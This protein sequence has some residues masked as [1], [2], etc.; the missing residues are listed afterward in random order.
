MA[1]LPALLAITVASLVSTFF[2]QANDHYK[3]E[4]DFAYDALAKADYATSLTHLEKAARLAAIQQAPAIDRAEIYDTLA[5]INNVQRRYAVAERYYIKAFE[6]LNSAQ[7]EPEAASLA[8]CELIALYVQQK[9]YRDAEPYCWHGLKAAE[10]SSSIAGAACI[11]SDLAFVQ[12]KQGKHAEALNN[13]NLSIPIMVEAFGSRSFDVAL[14]NSELGDTYLRLGKKAEA[15]KAYE[16]A[17]A[18]LQQA[19]L[20]NSPLAERVRL[21]LKR[22]Q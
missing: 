20:R 19:S 13:Y 21:T 10:A 5:D 14:V 2:P 16:K 17:D 7:N 12:A 22:L 11:R 4:R 1:T 15:L 18:V 9:R 6:T 8:A 3:S